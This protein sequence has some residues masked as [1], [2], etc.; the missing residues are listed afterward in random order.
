MSNQNRMCWSIELSAIT[1][2][3]SSVCRREQFVVS[4]Q[5]NRWFGGVNAKTRAAAHTL[6]CTRI[7]VWSVDNE[8]IVN[9]QNVN[10]SS[11]PFANAQI[12][13]KHNIKLWN[14]TH[15]DTERMRERERQL[16]KKRATKKYIYL[17]RTV[18]VFL[19]A[20]GGNKRNIKRISYRISIIF[21]YREN[22]TKQQNNKVQHDMAWNTFT[23]ASYM[24]TQYTFM[25]SIHTRTHTCSVQCTTHM[26]VRVP[27]FAALLYEFTIL[28][29]KKIYL[30]ALSNRQKRQSTK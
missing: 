26:S 17:M 25:Y 5:L 10:I 27:I 7:H 6:S 15:T 21:E 11:H 30:F 24:W 9:R 19:R 29:R 2:F 20:F 3:L 13:R 12:V 8:K 22:N 18:K 4:A 23:I 14:E 16:G 1:F 28:S